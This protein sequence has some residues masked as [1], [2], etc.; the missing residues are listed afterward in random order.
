MRPLNGEITCGFFFMK[1]LLLVSK[2]P[3]NDSLCFLGGRDGNVYLFNHG[4]AGQN[5][6]PDA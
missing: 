4:A 1:L 5:S 3:A 6:A 2:D